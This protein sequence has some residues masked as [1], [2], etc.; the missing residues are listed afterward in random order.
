L[1]RGPLP[2]A[3]LKAARNLIDS[4]TGVWVFIAPLL[5]GVGDT[6]PALENLLATLKDSGVA[7]VYVDPLNPYPP[8]VRN[9]RT[10]YRARFPLVTEYLEAYLH[11][12]SDYLQE[13]NGRLEHLSRQSGYELRLT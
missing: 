11:H 10:L 5:T 3:R 4:G 8:A 9:L 6:S 13:L 12:R 1:N 2:L 7:E